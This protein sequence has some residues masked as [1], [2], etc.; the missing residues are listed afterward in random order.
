MADKKYLE[1]FTSPAGEAV[2][3]WLTKADTEHDVAGVFHTDL[4]VPFELADE[5]I[6]K[7]EK[8]RDD[9]TATLT[10]AQQQALN[11][12]AVYKME[13]TRPTF[14]EG[15]TDDEKTAIK[16][17]FAPTETG[18][19]LFRFK[20]KQK[21]VTAS[22]EAFTQ[23][24]IIVLAE[25]GQRVES[26]V[27]GGS[28]IRVRGQIVP[29]TNAAAGMVGVTLRLKAVQVIDLKTGGAGGGSFW[30]D[31]FNEDAA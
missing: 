14:P 27:Y 13:L 19:V 8:A 1:A 24:P 30:T 10:V 21:V 26:P 17:T 20:L 25:T 15:A 2:Y 7:L 9:F 23:S 6:A 12:R 18:N 4:S 11:T 3:P 28:I 16:A 22:G 31:G 29:Y 5:F